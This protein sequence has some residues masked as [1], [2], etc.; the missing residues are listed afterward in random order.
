MSIT[1]ENRK[2]LEQKRRREIMASA[3]KLFYG[4]GFKET[5]MEAIAEEAGISKGL[6]YHY[7]KNKEDLLLSFFADME[8][9]LQDLEKLENPYDALMRFGCDF[10]V[11]DAEK[12]YTAPPIQILL[13]SFADRVI[14]VEKYERQNPIL[15]DFG[16][17]YLGK[18]FRK[19]MDMQIFRSGNA[20][21]FGDI[22]WS[23]LMGKLLPVKKGNEAE[24]PEIYV[25]EILSV[26]R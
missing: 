26:F 18:F 24:D 3:K 15:K 11:N 10:L 17:E 9:Y 1:E 20:R 23:F 21:E 8:E 25:K 16:R 12:Y 7:F 13:T 4:N 19:G 2:I 5:S 22:Y 14:A 6:I